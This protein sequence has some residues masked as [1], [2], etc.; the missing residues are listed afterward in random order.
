MTL[1]IIAGLIVWI[2]CVSLMLVIIK[3]G[4]SV[5]GN[6]YEQK[7]N[8][9]SLV[10]TQNNIKDSIKERVKKAAKTRRN[11]GLLISKVVY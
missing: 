6:K 5:R 9:K 1:C 8:A 11:Q 10:N 7:L 2:L 4:H 3:G